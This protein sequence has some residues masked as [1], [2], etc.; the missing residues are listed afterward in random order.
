[1]ASFEVPLPYFGSSDRP[2]H[3][4][5]LTMAAPALNPNFIPIASSIAAASP[6]PPPTLAT[7]VPSPPS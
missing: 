6:I 7:P 5:E 2:M 4:M 3:P 1:M